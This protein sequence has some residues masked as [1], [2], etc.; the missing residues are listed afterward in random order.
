MN[1]L[2]A[3]SDVQLSLA[4]RAP[5][6]PLEPDEVSRLAET[7]H[8]TTEAIL[9]EGGL[10]VFE[11]LQ[12]LER[13]EGIERDMENL[14]LVE[15]DC[16]PS[17][18]DRTFVA[19]AFE[20]NPVLEGLL[21]D[22]FSRFEAEGMSSVSAFYNAFRVPNDETVTFMWDRLR[23]DA[24]MSAALDLIV[25]GIPGLSAAE[26]ETA[27]RSKLTSRPFNGIHAKVAANLLS[28]LVAK[29]MNRA[30]SQMLI[31]RMKQS[32]LPLLPHGEALEDVEGFC[33]SLE[34]SMDFEVMDMAAHEAMIASPLGQAQTGNK[35]TAEKFFRSRERLG[36]DVHNNFGYVYLTEQQGQGL[37]NSEDSTVR[38]FRYMGKPYVAV[39][40]GL[41]F[42][43]EF[44][45]SLKATLEKIRSLAKAHEG[46]P[47]AEYYDKLVAYYEL[48]AESPLRGDAFL[49]AYYELCYEAER[50]WVRYVRYAVEQGLPYLHVHPFERYGTVSTKSH[51]LPLVLV[52][53]AETGIF[54][55]AKADFTSGARHFLDESGI[56]ERFP[57]MAEQSMRHVD[58][59][60][61]VSLAA[62]LHST[63][64]GTIA[65]NIPDEDAG[66]KEGIVTLFDTA[67]AASAIPTFRGAFLR[68]RDGLGGLSGVF[69]RDAKDPQKFMDHYVLF[70]GGHELNHNMYKGQKKPT[71]GTDDGLSVN[72][73]EEAKASEG[74]AFMFPDGLPL[75]PAELDRLRGA[76]P[77]VIPWML[78][79]LNGKNLADHRS[80]PYLREGAVLIDHMLK[81]GMLQVDRLR[82][83]ADGFEEK[84]LEG[85]PVDDEFEF[86]RYDLSDATI[87]GFAARCTEFMTRLAPDYHAA[88][89]EQEPEGRV[90][91]DWTHID[92]WQALS[93]LCYDRDSK[94][95]DPEGAAAIQIEKSRI[96]PGDPRNEEVVRALLRFADKE[97]PQQLRRALGTGRG[98]SDG[99]LEAALGA[100]KEEVLASH[101]QVIY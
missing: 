11:A 56:M 5:E 95:A 4:A 7:L 32:P 25:R 81:V 23:A 30:F 94:G 33:L 18:E 77:L 78:S 1:R 49:T 46:T 48:G 45:D 51:E 73:I 12:I 76:L 44:P 26:A 90:I 57:V 58:S 99:D 43:H 13:A 67:Y 75:K 29:C 82:V 74:M 9:V 83:T 19:E 68:E 50:A 17:L 21:E 24:R 92:T 36:E 55:E 100:F 16:L 89:F 38:E 98:V 8:T 65:E 42:A 71:K 47:I 28:E 22:L 54:S 53:P 37:G 88:E 64:A 15:G 40:V 70:V 87:Q 35:G 2:Q 34:V 52:N 41:Y 66:K 80:H 10:R 86:L 6:A 97:Q 96:K 14:P 62:R 3:I 84:P 72:T 31:R 79:R 39:P 27:L 61:M 59:A 101:P 63:L 91:P 93:R 69:D 85:T 60:V 20:N